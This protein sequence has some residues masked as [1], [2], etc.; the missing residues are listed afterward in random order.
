MRIGRRRSRSTQTPAG[1]L[2]NTNGRNASVPNRANSKGLTSRSRT[3]T[4]GTARCETCVPKWLIVSA[5]HN[6]RKSGSR[7]KER[8]PA[9]A[10]GT[11]SPIRDLAGLRLRATGQEVVERHAEAV[12]RPADEVV[13]PDGEDDVHHLLRGKL[14]SQCLPGLIRDDG[15]FIKIVRG[16]KQ[17]TFELRPPCG[18]PLLHALDLFFGDA[19]SL[20]D[21]DMLR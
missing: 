14:A 8:E 6:L 9:A 5:H 2:N 21:L 12:Q 1:R 7:H 16:L 11:A 13:L 18:R 20:R 15:A 3:A 17:R 10:C 19:A 4:S